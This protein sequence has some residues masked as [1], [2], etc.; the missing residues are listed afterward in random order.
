MILNEL[1]NHNKISGA[2]AAGRNALVD[3]INNSQ[4]EN[5][6]ITGFPPEMSMYLS[7]IKQSGL[8]HFDDGTWRLCPDPKHDNL[9]IKPLWDGIK[10]S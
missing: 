2:A 6:G 9:N 10:Y 5:L 7:L 8:H 3:T 4:M 1:I